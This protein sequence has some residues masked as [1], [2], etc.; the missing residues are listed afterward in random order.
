MQLSR[1][2]H[3]VWKAATSGDLARNAGTEDERSA[4]WVGI[5]RRQGR[6]EGEERRFDVHGKAG[7]PVLDCGCV[8]VAVGGEARVALQGDEYF[9]G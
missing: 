9:P 6:T 2:G 8:E 5:E 3:A 4:V 7:V 1:F